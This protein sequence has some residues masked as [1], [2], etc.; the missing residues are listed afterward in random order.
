MRFGSKKKPAQLTQVSPEEYQ[1]M[2]DTQTAAYA[3]RNAQ[4]APA[5]ADSPPVHTLQDS[6]IA[7]YTV[8][9]KGGLR[10]LPKAKLG[11]I[12][13]EI[14]PDRFRLTA[15]NNVARKFWTSMDIP[16]AQV[17]LVELTDRNVSTFEGIAGGLNSRQLNQQN[18]IHFTFTG[19]DG[20]TVLR[21]EML[22]G[23]SVMGQAKKAQEFQDVLTSHQIRSHFAAAAQPAS[24]GPDV[25]TRL[26]QLDS[27][28]NSG[29]L[30][31]AEF[32][33]KRAEIISRI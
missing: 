8:T 21:V 6:V 14:L 29:V 33:A 7:T 17:T 13:L 2:L 25:T 15:G 28:H 30:T 32:T 9:Y 26:T 12:T 23:V 4:A 24:D 10:N 1:R 22:T 16:F 5:L 11:K 18:N 3:A 27:L 31:D 20:P 19:A